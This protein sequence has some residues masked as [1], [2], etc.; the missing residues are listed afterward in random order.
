[1]LVDM[2][3]LILA[4]VATDLMVATNVDEVTV[5]VATSGGRPQR[6]SDNRGQQP[7]LNL[8]EK[9]LQDQQL[10]D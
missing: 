10:C 2:P 8:F 9:H 1:M 4:L 3:Q 5:Q 6:V 7:D